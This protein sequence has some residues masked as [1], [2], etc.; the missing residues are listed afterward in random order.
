[1]T[2]LDKTKVQNRCQLKLRITPPAAEGERAVLSDVIEVKIKDGQTL[3]IPCRG[4]Y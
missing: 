1:V 2:L 3:S 4:F